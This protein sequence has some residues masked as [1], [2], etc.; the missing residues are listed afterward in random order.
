M[1]GKPS[2][3]RILAFPFGLVGTDGVRDELATTFQ[4]FLLTLIGAGR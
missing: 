3:T 1:T 4:R 2:P